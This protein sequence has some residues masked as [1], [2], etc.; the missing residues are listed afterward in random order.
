MIIKKFLFNPFPVNTYVLVDEQSKEAAVVDPGCY[1]SDELQTLVD[2]INDNGLKLKYILLTHLHLDHCFGITLLKK[3]YPGAVFCANQEDDFLLKGAAQQAAA[4][5]LKMPADP[6]DIERNLNEGDEL[7]LGEQ[8]IDVIAVPGHSPGS[9][10]YYMPESHIIVVGDVLFKHSIGRTDLPK[11]NHK[12]LLSNIESKLFTLPSQ[13]KVYC[14]HGPE[15]T[16]GDE[17][18]FNPFF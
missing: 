5:G 13:T 4:Y 12:D 8:K 11:G 16:I 17:N 6:I 1:N 7:A 9:L 18:N 2:Y 14:G 10:C 15:T 3:V